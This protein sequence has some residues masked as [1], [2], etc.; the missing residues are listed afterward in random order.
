[1]NNENL[2]YIKL[3]YD[4]SL[5]TKRDILIT[6]QELITLLRTIKHYHS[7]RSEELRLKLKI[8]KKIRE[9]KLNVTKLEQVLPKIKIP[10]ILRREP[11]EMIKE[12]VAKKP[13]KEDSEKNIEEQL[14]EIQE[15]LKRLR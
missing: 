6:Q 7:L 1:M 15:K 9:L 11:E 12:Q 4:E 13:K 14:K 3:D 8:Q 10:E 2:I 5:V